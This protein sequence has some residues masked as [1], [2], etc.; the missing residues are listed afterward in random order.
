MDSNFLASLAALLALG[1]PCAALSFVI[2]RAMDRHRKLNP[3]R[4][5]FLSDGSGSRL[6]VELDD[7]DTPR[8]RQA[9]LERAAR[10]LAR[11]TARGARLKGPR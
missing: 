3:V 1:L 8:Q 7:R 4:V 5:Y 2:G 10:A 6:R 9:A 11:E